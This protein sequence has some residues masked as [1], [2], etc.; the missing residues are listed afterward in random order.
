[1]CDEDISNFEHLA[2]LVGEA[3]TSLGRIMSGTASTPLGQG[4]GY[5]IVLGLGFA[6]AIFMVS[7]T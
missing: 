6:F 5:G 4:Y 2:S 1:M 3:S 7:R